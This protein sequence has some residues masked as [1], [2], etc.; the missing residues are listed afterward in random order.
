MS[1][2]CNAKSIVAANGYVLVLIRILLPVQNSFAKILVATFVVCCTVQKDSFRSSRDVGI[3]FWVFSS[4]S[5]VFTSVSKVF[6]HFKGSA[7][8]HISTGIKYSVVLTLSVRCR[9]NN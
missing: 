9:T 2:S 5:R 4:F 3:K 6:P 7:Y 1:S 8:L